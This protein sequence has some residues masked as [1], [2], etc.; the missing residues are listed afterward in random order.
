M[1]GNDFLNYLNQTRCD[2]Q[3]SEMC[4]SLV[5]HKEVFFMTYERCVYVI[6]LSLIFMLHKNLI[7]NQVLGI[8][9]YF[10]DIFYS[11]SSFFKLCSTLVGCTFLHFVLC[12]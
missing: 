12:A 2:Y 3:I 9:M 8:N 5:K 10:L 11:Y 4:I 1:F 7:L 6:S